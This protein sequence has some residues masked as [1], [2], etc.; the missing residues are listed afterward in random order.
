MF[1][2]RISDRCACNFHLIHMRK[3]QILTFF[4]FINVFA[5]IEWNSNE[6]MEQEDSI[7]VLSINNEEQW[8][9]RINVCCSIFLKG[10]SPFVFKN[11]NSIFYPHRIV[12]IEGSKIQSFFL[13]FGVNIGIIGFGRTQKGYC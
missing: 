12:R 11:V 6:N 9:N 7:H 8:S 10:N 4:L 5:T 1:S 3:P 13:L 2:S